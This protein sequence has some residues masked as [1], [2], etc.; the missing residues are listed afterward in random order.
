LI[1]RKIFGKEYKSRSSSL[2][3]FLQALV[4]SFHLGPDIILGTLL[5]NT[6][7]PFFF[8]NVRN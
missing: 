4:N 6:L 8:L 7:G 3:N 1:T 5:S 2:S